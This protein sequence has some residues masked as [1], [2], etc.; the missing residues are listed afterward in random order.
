MLEP[1]N[2]VLA[3]SYNNAGIACDDLHRYDDALMYYARALAIHS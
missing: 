2:P 3:A 1:D